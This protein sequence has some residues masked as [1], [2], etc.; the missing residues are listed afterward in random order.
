MFH[1]SLLLVFFLFKLNNTLVLVVVLVDLQRFLAF[2]SIM[3]QISITKT[4]DY[5][6]G[7][8]SILDIHY[9]LSIQ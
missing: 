5:D 1:V 7:H 3:Q 8:G 4:T 9:T 2:H 6:P